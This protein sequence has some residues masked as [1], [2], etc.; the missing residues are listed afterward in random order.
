MRYRSY[1]SQGRL[2][3]QVGGPSA[4]AQ[5]EPETFS[6]KANEV[7]RAAGTWHELAAR[8]SPSPVYYYGSLVVD[9]TYAQLEQ[10]GTLFSH[11]VPDTHKPT[12]TISPVFDSSPPPWVYDD[13]IALSMRPTFFI[14]EAT[15]DE[16]SQHVATSMAR[17]LYYPHSGPELPINVFGSFVESIVNSTLHNLYNAFNV[18]AIQHDFVLASPPS[19]SLNFRGRIASVDRPP[20]TL[21]LSKDDWESIFLES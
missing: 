11:H 2:L 19:R 21:A 20:A 13:S 16:D 3:D 8:M 9:V 1:E 18:P 4:A 17:I 14:G 15:F 6:I 12:I 10:E 5:L 7:S